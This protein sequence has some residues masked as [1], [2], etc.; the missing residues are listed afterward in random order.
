MEIDIEPFD[1]DRQLGLKFDPRK[2][3]LG[4]YFSLNKAVYGSYLGITGLGRS[5]STISYLG[6]GGLSRFSSERDLNVTQPSEFEYLAF[7]LTSYSRGDKFYSLYRTD[8]E[9]LLTTNGSKTMSFD[10]KE[11]KVSSFL[12]QFS[13]QEIMVPTLYKGK[14]RAQSP[15]IFVNSSEIHNRR[16]YSWVVDEEQN[17]LKAPINLNIEVPENCLS[18]RPTKIQD[19]DDYQYTFFCRKEDKTWHF[20]YIPMEAL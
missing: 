9:L 4:T 6:L 19:S 15:A 3:K 12:P 8:G 11:L 18:L 16:V 13:F 5:Q 20:K 2:D 10:S 14:G 7:D 1:Q 17:D